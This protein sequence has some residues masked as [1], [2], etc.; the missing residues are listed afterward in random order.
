L[1]QVKFARIGVKLAEEDSYAATFREFLMHSGLIVT[2]ITD[3][4]ETHLMKLD[5][6]ILAGDGSVPKQIRPH[7]EQWIQ[8]GGQL[9]CVASTWDMED[10]LSVLA[11]EN[12]PLGAGTIDSPGDQLQ[13]WPDEC[14]KLRFFGGVR[15]IEQLAQVLV[16][17]SHSSI[18]V[19]KNEVGEGCAWLVG[20]DLGQSIFHMQNGRSIET[21][22][23]E[24]QDGSVFFR[25]PNLISEEATMLDWNEDRLSLD[26]RPPIFDQPIA[27][28]LGEFFFRIVLN[29]FTET[30]LTPALHWYWPDDANGAA[31]LGVDCDDLDGEQVFLLKQQF[32]ISR[33]SVTWFVAAPGYPLDIFRMIGRWGDEVGLL[34]NS[35]TTQGWS[36]Y[37]LAPRRQT[38]SQASVLRMDTGV[39]SNS[40]MKIAL[41]LVL[42]ALAVKAGVKQGVL[43]SLLA[44]ATHFLFRTQH[45]VPL[46]CSK[47]RIT[48]LNQAHSRRPKTC[49]LS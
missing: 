28:Q 27:D 4:I 43:G 19:S 29:C 17:T 22:A 20:I 3:S 39:V 46:N 45:L 30:N 26:N 37:A 47:Y 40:F 21:H 14:H 36:E 10:V 1:D 42:G 15:A 12:A 6:L 2:W 49:T 18:A 24:P 48:F 44:H 13:F 11:F 41:R 32:D 5:M 34:F 35:S 8:R 9:I 25:G 31:V 33:V 7:L 16:R 23:I 38:T